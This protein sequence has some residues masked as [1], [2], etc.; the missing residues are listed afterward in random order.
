MIKMNKKDK[1]LNNQALFD[2]ETSHVVTVE[3]LRL[4]LN[5]LR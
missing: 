2:L 5:Q 1:V 4:R 3:L